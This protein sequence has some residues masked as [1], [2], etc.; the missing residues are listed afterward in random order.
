MAKE[1]G[2][3]YPLMVKGS[4][5]NMRDLIEETMGQMPEITIECSGAPPSVQTAIYVR[6]ESFQFYMLCL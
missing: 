4:P 2:A 3:D 5:E 6:I 1:L